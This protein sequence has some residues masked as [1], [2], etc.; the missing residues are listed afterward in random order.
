M[1]HRTLLLAAVPAVALVVLVY[2][3]SYQEDTVYVSYDD[4]DAIRQD[5]K[6]AGITMSSAVTLYNKEAVEYCSFLVDDSQ[7]VSYCTSTELEIGDEFLG[8]VHMAGTA[9]KPVLVL[10][11]MQSDNTVSQRSQIAALA[12]AMLRHTTCGAQHGQR[13][14][15]YG[16]F[17]EGLDSAESWIDHAIQRHIGG[18]GINTRSAVDGLPVPVLLEITGNDDGHLWKILVGPVP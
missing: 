1:R 3:V 12:D 17:P 13:N 9:A 7:P 5:L 15:P 16:S 4:G 2:A 14:C 10:G 11:V 8:N 6:A 18:G